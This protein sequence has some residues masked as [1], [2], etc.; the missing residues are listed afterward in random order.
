MTTASMLQD[1]EGVP[2]DRG[3]RRNEDVSIFLLMKR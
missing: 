3:I 1:E 2:R